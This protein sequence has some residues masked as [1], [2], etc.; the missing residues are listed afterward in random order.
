MNLSDYLYF[1]I[2][3]ECYCDK[4]WIISAFTYSIETDAQKADGYIGKL[5]REPFGVFYLDEE[6]QRQPIEGVTVKPNEPILSKRDKIVI[7][8]ERLPWIGEDKIETTIGK[9]LLNLI[10]I[11][12]PFNGRFPYVND[13]GITPS[14]I[15]KRF[16]SKLKDAVDSDDKREVGYFYVDEMIRF[17]KAVTFIEGLSKVFA[18]SITRAGILPAPGSD[19]KRKEL[20]KK[21]EGK[22]TDPTEMVKFQAELNEF[23]KAYLKE[24]DPGYGNFMAGKILKARAKSYLT[25]GGDSNGF[26]NSVEMVPITQPLVKGIDLTPDKFAA[27]SNTIRYGSFSRGAETVNGGVVAKAIMTALDTWK[28]EEADCG[29]KLSIKRTYPESDI[30]LLVGRY[31]VDK[32]GKVFL[33]ENKDQAKAFIDKEVNIRSPQYCSKVGGKT[34][35]ICAGV[36]LSRFEKGLVIPAMEVSSGIMSDSLKKMHDTTASSKLMQLNLVIS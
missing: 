7:T 25:Q 27:A 34:C 13:S 4:R 33:V 22:L 8:K 24:N 35:S 2:K 15:E 20:L 28:I 16:S 30:S 17:Q 19:E 21:Y 5:I 18:S 6:L 32:A 23:D 12:K 26:T 36:D 31:A 11:Y 9:L 29:T 14:D 3:H 10:V 1:A